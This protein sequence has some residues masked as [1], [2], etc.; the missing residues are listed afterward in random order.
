MAHATS[1]RQHPN[2]P[3]TV[4]GRRRMVGCV[5]DRLRIKT[6]PERTDE[7]SSETEAKWLRKAVQTDRS[8]VFGLPCRTR[9]F[10][11]RTTRCVPWRVSALQAEAP[12]SG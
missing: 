2:A 6:S 10:V 3:L 5:V 7:Y 9:L 4:E 1:R 12:L 11:A 8:G